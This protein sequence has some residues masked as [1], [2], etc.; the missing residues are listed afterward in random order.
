[1]TQFTMKS[2]FKSRFQLSNSFT[3]HRIIEV[4]G[5]A[6]LLHLDVAKKEKFYIEYSR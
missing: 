3:I 2:A 6:I 1:M 4:E 5:A